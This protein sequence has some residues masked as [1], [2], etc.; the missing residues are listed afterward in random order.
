MNLV[1]AL[2]QLAIVAG[3]HSTREIRQR[4]NPFNLFEE[5]AANANV[6]LIVAEFL[7][8]EAFVSLYAM[9]KDFNILANRHLLSLI[10]RN[11]RRASRGAFSAYPYLHY[12]WL[13]VNDPSG[14][15]SK[16]EPT[17]VRIVPGLRYLQMIHFRE[18]VVQDIINSLAKE[19]HYLPRWSAIAMK[20]VWSLMDI[21]TTQGRR[22][23]LESTKRWIYEDFYFATLFF[24]KVDMRFNRCPVSDG[25]TNLRKLCLHHRSLSF[26]RDVL[27]RTALVDAIDLMQVYAE[28]MWVP[29]PEHQALPI[30]GIPPQDIG[31]GL[32]E[33]WGLTDSRRPLVCVDHLI[34][35]EAM[36]RGF[37][38]HHRYHEFIIWGYDD[39]PSVPVREP[40]PVVEEVDPVMQAAESLMA[41]FAG[42]AG[43]AAPHPAAE[44]EQ[45]A[46]VSSPAA[47]SPAAASINNSS[48]VVETGL[49]DH[50]EENTMTMLVDAGEDDEDEMDILLGAEGRGD[51]SDEDEAQDDV[52]DAVE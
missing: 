11:T 49:V 42:G 29:Q 25:H 33:Y 17:K 12:K 48:M 50:E 23:Q 47:S 6:F 9:S 4:K 35:F 39:L 41:M 34:M 26:L 44:T 18:Q 21:P 8:A 37:D 3:V 19:G 5:L 52:M 15:K 32:I 40:E 45:P 28:Y 10:K 24:F 36:R 38:I 30:A 1:T 51:D 27:N 2:D 43:T 7:D 16:K 13:C 31:R 20:K 22:M 46:A 14:R